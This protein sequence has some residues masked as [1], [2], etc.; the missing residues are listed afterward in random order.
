MKNSLLLL[1]LITFSIGNVNAQN[2]QEKAIGFCS[3]TS[4]FSYSKSD[5]DTVTFTANPS[6]NS[7]TTVVGYLWNFGDGQTST[8]QNPTHSYSSDGNYS[9]SLTI[10]GFD[11]TTGDCC[12]NTSS[13]IINVNCGIDSCGVEVLGLF[14]LNGSGVNEV[15]FYATTSVSSGWNITGSFFTV[16]YADGSNSYHVGYTNAFGYQQIMIPVDCLHM[17]AVEKVEI[18]VYAESSSN[19]YCSDT[20][21]RNWYP[22]V[23][24]SSIT[25]SKIS[26][27]PV[28]DILNIDIQDNS[29]EKNNKIEAVLY[30]LKGVLKMKKIIRNK[31]TSS[32]DVNQI[33]SGVYI[34]KLFSN[35]KL[36]ESKKIIIA[37]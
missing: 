35:S 4:N 6:S 1:L 14:E 22:G 5:C 36:I 19:T 9:V 27:N 21:I 17:S 8:S 25:F 3:V 11:T 13:Q 24:G 2:E 32:I 29:L 12:N 23:C 16:T 37:D 31:Q 7:N 10:I 20:K 15:A 18:N 34:L 28:K 26:P 33:K 30:D